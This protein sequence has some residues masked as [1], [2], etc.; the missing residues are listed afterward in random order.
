MYSNIN[1]TN[2][3]DAE[4]MKVLFLFLC[5]SK[6]M[7]TFSGLGSFAHQSLGGFRKCTTTSNSIIVLI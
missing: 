6:C 5:A 1:I 2:E 3:V 7:Y 4:P